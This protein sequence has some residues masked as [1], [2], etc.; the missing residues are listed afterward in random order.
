MSTIICPSCNEETSSE[1]NFCTTCDKQIK[2]LNSTC[3]KLLIKG[4]TFCFNCGQSINAITTQ[5]QPNKYI[6]RLQDGKYEEYE[7]FNVSDHAVTELAPFIVGRMNVRS[8]QRTHPI[9]NIDN[10]FE[11]KIEEDQQLDEREE[12]LQLA[13]NEIKTDTIANDNETSKYFRIDGEVLVSI[14]KDFKGTTWAEQQKRFVILYTWAYNKIF[15]KPVPNKEHF[16]TVAQS[17]SVYDRFKFPS[18]LEAIL[19][20]ELSSTST[21][22]ILSSDGEKEVKKILEEI[23]NVNVKEGKKYWDRNSATNDKRERL[24]ADDKKRIESWVSETVELGQLEIRN[25]SSPT[26]YALLALWILTIHL[27]KQETVRRLDAYYYLK[28]KY[29]SVSASSSNFSRAMSS[30]AAKKFIKASDDDKYYLTTDGQTLVENWINGSV[31][32]STSSK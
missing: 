31:T 22:Y 26:D 12:P 11:R 3:N 32:V 25:I 16:K 21:G 1:H 14:H 24:K 15:N 23:E 4:K 8:Q 20:K 2:C 29:P 28:S 30:S 7:E 13:A 9:K 5:N 17:A 27:K 6:R 19:K 18:Y 10:S